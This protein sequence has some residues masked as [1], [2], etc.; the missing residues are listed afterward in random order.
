MKD[1]WQ[2]TLREVSP[3]GIR[4]C[5]PMNSFEHSF[6]L[7]LNKAK[8]EAG[9]AMTGL[10]DALLR[11]RR[12]EV[13]R[14]LGQCMLSLQGYE[15]LIKAI[16]AQHEIIGRV[17]SVDEARA[18]RIYDLARK[19]LG[20]L[21]GQLLNS[22]LEVD[23]IQSRPRELDDD[24]PF[25]LRMQLALSPDDF[26]RTVND[27]RELVD[28]R[29]GLVHHFLEQHDL[30]SL[31]GC[32]GAL[33]ALSAAS[34]RIEQANGDLRTWAKDLERISQSAATLVGSPAMYDFIVRGVI[35][36]PITVIVQALREAE[37]S[38]AIDGWTRVSSAELWISARYPEELPEGYGCKSWRQVIHESGLFKL[39]YRQTDGPREAWYRG[40]CHGPYL[41]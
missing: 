12:Q 11:Q 41:V 26:S 3:F 4:V 34:A 30:S 27:L 5:K 23:G 40:K 29:N 14:R 9:F 36:W 6:K 28:L 16:L 10:S 31:V 25:A 20:S 7:G 13:Q 8:H 15:L 2:V 35:T 24:P 19:P 32:D 1:Q 38:L 37:A 18:A 39:I 17:T 33:D 22:F 21:V